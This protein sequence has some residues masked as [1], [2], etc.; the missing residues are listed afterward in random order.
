[1]VFKSHIGNG[2]FRNRFGDL[3]F[4]IYLLVL[5]SQLGACESGEPV[6]LR[7]QA[8]SRTE[9]LGGDSGVIPAGW[10]Y[11]DGDIH[12]LYL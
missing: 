1:M 12:Y 2:F 8:G 4:F 3:S 6:Q 11:L 9:K 5:G 7:F 10:Y